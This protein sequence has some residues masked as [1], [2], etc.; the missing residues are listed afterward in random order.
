MTRAAWW[1]RFRCWLGHH[2]PNRSRFVLNA[3]SYGGAETICTRCSRTL[4]MDSQGNWF[5]VSK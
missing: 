5:A 1:G 4:L 2:T 3:A